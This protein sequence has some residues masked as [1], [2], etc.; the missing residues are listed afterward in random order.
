MK[1]N[2]I[3][4]SEFLK[5]RHFI[6]NILLWFE[7]NNRKL[8]WRENRTP[9]STYISE[10]ML[11]QTTVGAVEKKF[12]IFLKKYPNFKSFI[13]SSEKELLTYWSGLGYYRRARNLWSTVKIINISYKSEIPKE[14][15]LLLSLPGIGVYTAS[16]IRTIGFNLPDSPVDINIRRVFS[17]LYGSELGH[18]QIEIILNFI[19][20]KNHSRDFTEAL[21]DLSSAIKKK[22]DLIINDL[23]LKK[24]L[25][26]KNQKK[27]QS[28]KIK[29]IPNKKIKISF[30]II[31]Y[32]NQIAFLKKS[33]L[34]F[35]DGFEH[36]P[37]SQDEFSSE[38]FIISQSKKIKD[39]KYTITNHN[40]QIKVFEFFTKSRNKK[41]K[42]YDLKDIVNI[43]LPTLYKKILALV[44]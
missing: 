3:Q 2:I 38:L 31:R 13:K 29:K 30:F 37:N 24:Y 12:P 10:I 15:K 19:W 25:F 35:F 1:S 27:I 14:K 8:I 28:I 11:Q 40:F 34:S 20:P 36:L 32:K 26:S 42:W 43:P 6:E 33:N 9:Y 41:F 5:K 39:I 18:K 16:A 23:D 7:K 17:G 4:F 21:M 44:S 22:N